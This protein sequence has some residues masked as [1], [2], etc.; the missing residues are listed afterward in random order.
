M[1]DDGITIRLRL[2]DVVVLGCNEL[3]RGIEVV[4]R[5]RQEEA[6]CPRCG[7]PTWQVH[8]W[9]LQRKRDAKLWS[10]KVWLALFKRRFRCRRCGKVFM[11][12]DQACGR[13]RRTTRRLRETL[14]QRAEETTIRAVARDESVSEGLVQRSWVEAHSI[15]S[16]PSRSHTLLGLDGFCVRR[17]GRMWTGM[18]DLETRRPWRSFPANGR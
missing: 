10:K 7:C 16:A 5:Y 13:S 4:G 12:P 9:H 8:Q 18:W 11:E 6:T 14:S 17:P 1:C 2:K 3:E 15:V